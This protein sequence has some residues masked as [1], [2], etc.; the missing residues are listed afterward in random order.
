[1]ALGAACENIAIASGSRGRPAHF[2]WFPDDTD[3]D[4]A[5]V[6]TFP[7]TKSAPANDD[8]RLFR[9]LHRRGTDR[10]TGGS[11]ALSDTEKH[12]LHVAAGVHGAVLHL[13]EDRTQ[14]ER[15]AALLGTSDRIRFLNPALHRQL[16]AELRWTEE[17]SRATGD[18]LDVTSLGLPAGGV[19]LLRLLARPG[20]SSF[21]A[22]HDLGSRLDELQRK[23]LSATSALAV[24]AVNGDTPLDSLRGGRAVQRV[25]LEATAHLV[26]VQPVTPLTLG[27]LLKDPGSCLSSADRHRLDDASRGLGA[28]LG[29]RDEVPV[30]V[31]RLHRGSSVTPTRSRRR[32]V[33]DVL[34]TTEE[35]T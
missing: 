7:P 2:T 16:V 31:L 14:I 13:V 35:M 5:A 29:D 11:C 23:T 1:V 33:H 6:A 3:E 20:V 12:A 27:G 25:W 8:T 18:G 19:E 24:V 9:L 21:L 30:L 26:A 34:T 10:G 17:I 22:R 28:F 15:Y 4:L 32:A